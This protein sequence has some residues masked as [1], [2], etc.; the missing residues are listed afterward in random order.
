MSEQEWQ[1]SEADIV[2]RLRA[3][4]LS[5]YGLDID[6]EL[7]DE[8]WQEIERLRAHNKIIMGRDPEE[9][10]DS[11]KWMQDEI[12]RLRAALQEIRELNDH[13][14]T[15]IEDIARRALEGK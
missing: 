9:I 1:S 3:A 4:S 15:E 14:D 11:Y 6:K 2:E 8:G 13:M 12:K 10:L 7:M 5:L